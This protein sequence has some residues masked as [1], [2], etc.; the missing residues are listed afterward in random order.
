MNISNT[1]T[2]NPL[3]IA[4]VFNS[5]FTTVA[6]NL[7]TKNF[8]GEALLLVF[9]AKNRHL[10]LSNSDIHD[11]TRENRNL[12]LRTTNLT[13]VQKGVLYS[14]SRIYNHLPT[15][16]KTLSNDLKHF[17]SKLKSFFLSKIPFIA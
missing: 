16:I 8:S 10:F 1:L 9:V 6:E 17:K 4:N 15:H 7:T 14:G 13:L 12:H 3:S 2:S 11:N 5:Y